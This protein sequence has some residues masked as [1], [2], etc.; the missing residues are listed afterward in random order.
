MGQKMYK[1]F[2]E[3]KIITRVH[4][5]GFNGNTSKLEHIQVTYENLRII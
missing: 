4:S 1:S 5:V 3:M 2:C